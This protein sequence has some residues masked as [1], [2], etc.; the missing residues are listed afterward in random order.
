MHILFVKLNIDLFTKSTTILIIASNK[1]FGSKKINDR[2]GLKILN[3][4]T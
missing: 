3:H 2:I 4:T 1:T